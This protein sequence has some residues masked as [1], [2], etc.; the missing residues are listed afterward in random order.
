MSDNKDVNIRVLHPADAK[1]FQ[2]LRLQGL[3]ESP[4][5]FGSSYEEE[6]AKTLKEL[7][8]R[9]K[10]SETAGSFVLGAFAGDD[11]IGMIGLSRQQRL[12]YRHKA[13]IWGM[14]VAP[15]WRRQ[16]VGQ[17]LLDTTISRSKMIAG[18][19]QITLIVT[20]SNQAARSLYRSRGFVTFG[21]EEESLCWEGIC[22]AMEYMQLKLT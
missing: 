8:D 1:I 14:Y 19:K 10:A 4:T 12:K 20:H 9:L 6:V 11:L 3:Q 7:T 21:I 13:E 18:L 16:G 17:A 2:R 5:A 22:F 15:E